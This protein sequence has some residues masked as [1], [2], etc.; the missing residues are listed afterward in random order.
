[1]TNM[2]LETKTTQ[3]HVYFA[4]GSLR[5]GRAAAGIVW[6]KPSPSDWGGQGLHFSVKTSN[7]NLVELYAIDCALEIATKDILETK[8][9]TRKTHELLIFSDSQD[10]LNGIRSFKSQRS[11]YY[12]QAKERYRLLQSVMERSEA[13]KRQRVNLELHWVPGHKDVPGNTLA[14]HLAVA[15]TKPTID[16]R[17]RKEES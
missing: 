10:A 14:D 8:E 15:T 16:G 5:S 13:L 6:R 7:S 12:K 2:L 4:D 3:Y 11:P 9:R 17:G 1:M